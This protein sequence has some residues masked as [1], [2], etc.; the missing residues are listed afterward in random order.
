MK[1]FIY[2]FENG[3][4]TN[5]IIT[6]FSELND[7]ITVFCHISDFLYKDQKGLID[8]SLIGHQK[9]YGHAYTVNR[10]NIIIESNFD[11]ILENINNH[12]Y[13]LCIFPFCNESIIFNK[14]FNNLLSFTHNY[15]Q[16]NELFIIDECDNQSI[17]PL[18]IPISSYLYFKRE[19]TNGNMLHSNVFI[20][21]I[22]YS[23]PSEKFLPKNYNKSQVL[24]NSYY[25]EGMMY[26]TSLRSSLNHQS[27]ESYFNEY[28]N[29]LFAIT[30]KRGGYDRMVHY[31][32]IAGYCLPVFIDYIYMPRTVMT[33]WPSDLQMLA[34][35][36]WHQY[37]FNYYFNETKYFN[38]LDQFYD[39]AYKNL[40]YEKLVKYLL[41]FY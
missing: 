23:I 12:Y 22:S 38:L 35:S 32:I 1:I 41:S 19:F 27:I 28:N 33:T 3:Y 20:F 4:I 5:S 7:E 17:L 31:E 30:G 40:T 25:Y 13:D 8:E 14:D 2:N 21:P 9:L 39:Y 15:Y 37:E 24:I 6:G 29:S 16:T 26:D 11:I 18:N 36:Y 10:N 34:N